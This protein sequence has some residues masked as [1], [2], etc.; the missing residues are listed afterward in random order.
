MQEAAALSESSAGWLEHFVFAISRN[1]KD[2][3][4]QREL[5]EDACEPKGK[6]FGFVSV[7][8]IMPRCLLNP[9]VIH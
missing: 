2:R 4:T 1:C 5:D 7:L 3:F 8:E 9:A 6:G